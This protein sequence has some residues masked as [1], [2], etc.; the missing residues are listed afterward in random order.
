MKSSE[1]IKIVDSIL[2]TKAVGSI[3]DISADLSM[4]E[5]KDITQLL[6]DHEK[7]TNNQ[8]NQKVL[9]DQETVE[10]PEDEE[11]EDLNTGK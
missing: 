6:K 11:E 7:E 2:L 8:E 1:N 10:N 3:E 9:I 5:G 4:P